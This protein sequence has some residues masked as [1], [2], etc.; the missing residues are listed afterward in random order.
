MLDLAVKESDLM[1]NKL[2]ET[3]VIVSV[4]REEKEVICVL[5]SSFK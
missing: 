1:S 4:G 3:A 5:V 2:F